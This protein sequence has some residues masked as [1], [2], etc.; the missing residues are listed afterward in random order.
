MDNCKASRGYS[1]RAGEQVKLR[2]K[3]SKY[4]TTRHIQIFADNG[5]ADLYVKAGSEATITDWDDSPYWQGS[6]EWIVERIN[7]PLQNDEWYF[8]L[9][10]AAEAF[11]NLDIYACF[12]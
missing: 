7:P 12:V 1:A 10:D 6:S 4:A 2:V 8:I 11:H 3:A 5:D 9:I